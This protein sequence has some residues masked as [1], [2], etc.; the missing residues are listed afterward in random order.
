MNRLEF[1]EKFKDESFFNYRNKKVLVINYFR[2][3][4]FVEVFLCS[5]HE[6]FVF[7]LEHY[8]VKKQMSN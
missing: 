3:F 6:T 5:E 4:G 8:I 1:E 2:P 7:Q